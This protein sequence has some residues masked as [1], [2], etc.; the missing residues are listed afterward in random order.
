M[1]EGHLWFGGANSVS[2]NV[3]L[4]SAN[5]PPP[6]SSSRAPQPLFI[7]GRRRR[8]RKR[9]GLET[10]PAR[11]VRP[12][13]RLARPS[14]HSSVSHAHPSASPGPPP[15][16]PPY[17]PYPHPHPCIQLSHQTRTPWSLTAAVFS[18]ASLFHV[19]YFLSRR[20]GDGYCR[21]HRVLAC[22]GGRGANVSS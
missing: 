21:S 8:N 19:V 11:L 5:P 20:H 13:L 22:F 2:S 14:L 9:K 10:L 7:G 4:F 18:P 1:F 16:L 17:P 6:P 12:S 3:S 15:P